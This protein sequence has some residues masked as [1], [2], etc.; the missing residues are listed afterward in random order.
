MFQCPT[1]LVSLKLTQNVNPRVITE[2]IIP[3]LIPIG[4]HC[5]ENVQ[6]LFVPSSFQMVGE[7]NIWIV[8]KKQVFW[9]LG[10]KQAADKTQLSPW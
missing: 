3:D 6:V 10:V 7:R 8:N 4:S 5:E 1:G 9:G 2:P